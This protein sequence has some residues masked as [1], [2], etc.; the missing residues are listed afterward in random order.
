MYALDHFLVHSL[1]CGSV[2]PPEPTQGLWAPQRPHRFA[3]LLV[4]GRSFTAA[5][6]ELVNEH[7]WVLYRHGMQC[8]RQLGVEDLSTRQVYNNA[9]THTH[10]DQGHSWAQQ[11]L[12][13]VFCGVAGC[14]G[15][16]VIA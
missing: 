8:R 14:L 4:P 13:F 3:H 9:H 12:L 11:L 6:H 1:Q 2:G 15:L 5:V 7:V 16:L 10:T